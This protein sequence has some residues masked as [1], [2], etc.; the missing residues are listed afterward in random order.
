MH[1][2]SGS[3]STEISIKKIFM[4]NRPEI[5]STLADVVKIIFENFKTR[6]QNFSQDSVFQIQ[7]LV[8]GMSLRTIL[9]P[10]LR[11]FEPFFLQSNYSKKCSSRCSFCVAILKMEC[12]YCFKVQTHR[13]MQRHLK[14]C[15]VKNDELVQAKEEIARL[16]AEND[17]LKAGHFEE[18]EK[19]KQ[20][21]NALKDKLI[22]EC[23]DKKRKRSVVHNDNRQYMNI[24][25]ITFPYGEEP[26]LTEECI[27][28]IISKA[29]NMPHPQSG[30]T[31][32]VPLVLKEKHFKDESTANIRIED[33]KIETV[34]RD[35]KTGELK[36]KKERKPAQ[37]FC[38]DLAKSTMQE[39]NEACA[40]ERGNPT[41]FL[42]RSYHEP[43]FGQD[44]D[45]DHANCMQT[46]G[47]DVC[48]MLKEQSKK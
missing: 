41:S 30:L 22:V 24:I 37:K 7:N 19:L 42:W 2:L 9:R 31:H 46:V 5:Y 48:E 14:I 16:K 15:R 4:E 47:S 17:Q 8:L 3:A 10:T 21:I 29:S 43:R 12:T 44:P 45:P 39:L 18:L 35:E 6:L 20:E 13:H 11:H 25:N 23:T 27:R 1:Y 40:R 38:E 34:Q 26:K 36:W 33:D 28:S 32:T